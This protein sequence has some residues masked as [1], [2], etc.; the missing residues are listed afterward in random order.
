MKPIGIEPKDFECVQNNTVIKYIAVNKVKRQIGETTEEY[1]IFYCSFF[2]KNTLIIFSIE[3][4]CDQTVGKIRKLKEA[5]TKSTDNSNRCECHPLTD[6][7]YKIKKNYQHMFDTPENIRSYKLLP[8]NDDLIE[9]CLLVLNHENKKLLN[10][11]I[12]SWNLNI[13]KKTLTK[14]AKYTCSTHYVKVLDY[15]ISKD[16][17][18]T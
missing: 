8:L 14:I 11:D 6:E 10:H 1:V 12:E 18:H 17:Q 3:I 2:F 16:Q 5:K 15:F 7:C 13:A 4:N 9:E